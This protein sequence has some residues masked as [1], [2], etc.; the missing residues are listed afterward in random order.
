MPKQVRAAACAGVA[1][2]PAQLIELYPVLQQRLAIRRITAVHGRYV[3]GFEGVGQQA[4]RNT[5]IGTPCEVDQPRLARYEV[6]RNHDQLMADP[7]QLWRQLGGQQQSGVGV[8]LGQY[9][10]RC[11]PQRLVPGPDQLAAPDVHA[12]L[13][14]VSAQAVI[15]RVVLL[16]GL[17]QGG[18]KA[19]AGD[20]EVD[21]GGFVRDEVID[22]LAQGAVPVL[23]EAV[24]Q[25]LGHRPDAEHVDVGEI[26]VGFGVEI[27][28]AQVAPANDGHAVIGQP[29][30]V[31]HAP[32][33]Q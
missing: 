15:Q 20:G 33:L 28:V 16:T 3:G 12:G 9:L 19:P 2:L 11:V 5:R 18:F 8:G 13:G 27:L 24:T 31:M 1:R 22:R 21:L 30:L 6:S 29:Q 32:V 17:S 14:L 7:R 26:Q 25:L 4:H 23:V 10:A